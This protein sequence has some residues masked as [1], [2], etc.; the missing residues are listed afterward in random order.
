MEHFLYQG[1]ICVASKR[2]VA[3]CEREVLKQIR[4]LNST[5]K[6]SS[7]EIKK[8]SGKFSSQFKGEIQ[9]DFLKQKLSIR[10]TFVPPQY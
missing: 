1:L 10:Q 7:L 6:I 9:W 3:E 4:R 8:L 2:E 5:G